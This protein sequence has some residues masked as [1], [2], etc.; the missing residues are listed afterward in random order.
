MS[1]IK[2]S[3][4]GKEYDGLYEDH[5]CE[6]I[7]RKEYEEKKR[8][9]EEASD[10]KRIFMYHPDMPK[11]VRYIAFVFSFSVCGMALSIILTGMLMVVAPEDIH[12]ASPGLSLPLL[13]I[14]CVMLVFLNY[15]ISHLKKWSIP[16]FVVFVVFL[17]IISGDIYFGPIG[18]IGLVIV[19]IHRKEFKY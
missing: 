18:L 8:K 17:F 14:C 2:C 19:I 15:G 7:K 11:L 16:L 3:K 6:G 5:V 13:F 12:I 4:C 9:W 10:L 1:K